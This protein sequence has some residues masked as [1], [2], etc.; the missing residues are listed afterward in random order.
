MYRAI[1]VALVV[2]AATTTHAYVRSMLWGPVVFDDVWPLDA[3]SSAF[4]EVSAVAWGRVWSCDDAAVTPTVGGIASPIITHSRAGV[5]FTT[6]TVDE[7]L[8]AIAELE[9]MLG[10]VATLHCRDAGPVWG[11]SWV[12]A[13]IT[14]YDKD[15]GHT[16]AGVVVTC[17][18]GPDSDARLVV[19][20][21]THESPGVTD[22][23]NGP[24]PLLR[25]G[26]STVCV[27]TD[28]GVE[29]CTSRPGEPDW[30]TAGVT[31]RHDFPGDASI[32]TRCTA[33]PPGTGGPTAGLAPCSCA[34]VEEEHLPRFD[35]C[36]PCDDEADD[37]ALAFEPSS[38][39]TFDAPLTCSDA[40]TDYARYCVTD[41]TNPIMRFDLPWYGWTPPPGG[42]P[43]RSA[44]W[45]PVQCNCYDPNRDP[46][47]GT[48]KC[49]HCLPGWYE[50]TDNSIVQTDTHR[51]SWRCLECAAAMDADP[52]APDCAWDTGAWRPD[53]PLNPD[54]SAADCK[55]TLTSAGTHGGYVSVTAQCV[56][57][58]GYI[59]AACDICAEGYV[60]LDGVCAACPQT[61][62]PH[63]T[64]HCSGSVDTVTL[65]PNTT[66]CECSPGF[67]SVDDADNSTATPCTACGPSVCGPGGNCN[68]DAHGGLVVEE[69][70][71]TCQ[72]GWVHNMED[73]VIQAGG[74]KCS[75]CGSS[76]SLQVLRDGVG[77]CLDPLSACSATSNPDRL[78]V[79]AS[80]AA[81]RCVCAD[82]FMH[83]ST[84]MDATPLEAGVDDD[85]VITTF[86]PGCIPVSD[87]CGVAGHPDG[88]NATASTVENTCVCQGEYTLAPP[89]DPA[90]ALVPG[91]AELC[92]HIT[93]LCG[94]GAVLTDGV[95]CTCGPRWAPI[96]DQPVGGRCVACV[97]ALHTGP[98]C[99]KCGTACPG[100]AACISD[101][102]PDGTPHVCACLSG[103]IDAPDG[104]P[105]S[106]CDTEDVGAG[107]A[108]VADVTG[109]GCY[110]C[111]ACGPHGTCALDPY[112]HAS[113]CVCDDGW[114]HTNPTSP[115]SPCSVCVATGGTLDDDNDCVPCDPLCASRGV[116]KPGGVC[117]CTGSAAGPPAC[118][119]C[120]PGTAGPGCPPCATQ[121]GTC[122]PHGTCVWESA[123]LKHVCACDGGWT[124]ASPDNPASPCTAC[125]NTQYH[126]LAPN[127]TLCA[128]CPGDDGCS[129]S[130][131]CVWQHDDT[132]DDSMG[133]APVC[134]CPPG[135][136][137]DD[138]S[139]CDPLAD[140]GEGCN[141]CSCWRDTPVDAAWGVR[142]ASCTRT[143]SFQTGSSLL[144]ACQ[145]APGWTH[146]TRGDPTSSCR[147]CRDGV[148]TSG[149][150]LTCPRCDPVSETCVET[151]A[152]PTATTLEE[153]GDVTGSVTAVVNVSGSGLI[154]MLATCVCKP[155]WTRFPGFLADTHGC[156]PLAVVQGA[157]ALLA[158]RIDAAAA[159]L[160]N[161]DVAEVN[162]Q[163]LSQALAGG[164]ASTGLL[165]QFWVSVF[166]VGLAAVAMGGVAVVLGMRTAHAT[167]V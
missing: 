20:S 8:D 147:P 45:P 56:C 67:W 76:A 91:V 100:H 46:A 109:D 64:R 166:V 106:V 51:G 93:A 102:L 159:S 105:C 145:C 66:W 101:A 31:L 108:W 36:V 144:H 29:Q 150:C 155:G 48:G 85:G 88:V 148:E 63:G 25:P 89:S 18:V 13:G 156:Y 7:T 4:A 84:L 127:G 129:G 42:D 160:H 103:W 23:V 135:W 27:Q 90:D 146:V 107:P 123:T 125:P 87:V 95:A 54:P 164:K 15:T 21:P 33:N 126:I 14:A 68:L 139:L 32:A 3:P 60:P 158:D 2:A 137:G 40:R 49:L 34:Y 96:D 53:D 115:T 118:M 104:A 80:T 26:A 154:V 111:A 142:G 161:Q 35:K 43:A 12:D 24:F 132:R 117:E 61:C 78:D 133:G 128:A 140:E 141:T 41:W 47:P 130:K 97:D 149:L 30:T 57:K 82:G 72:P 134:T 167:R 83:V 6:P 121:T 124:H 131:Q 74:F 162:H 138:C 11:V 99:I 55:A 19:P 69:D 39:R 10:F 113:V 152:D 9:D 112:R 153:L 5:A 98:Q 65:A 17:C 110:S 92:T 52:S 86:A 136:F 70:L 163:T 22:T 38:T 81:G 151:P 59:G 62:G 73:P 58:E 119:Q 1:V 94:P 79:A 50:D 37:E 120:E 143:S 114:T 157:S 77:T 165:V 116:C 28:G 16:T 75:A 71:C 44:R 122:G